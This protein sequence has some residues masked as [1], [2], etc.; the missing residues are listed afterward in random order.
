MIA[1]VRRMLF[2]TLEDRA[3]APALTTLGIKGAQETTPA[4]YSRVAELEQ[5]SVE[6]HYPELA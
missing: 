3:L 1:T 4:A 6:A 5:A 2:E